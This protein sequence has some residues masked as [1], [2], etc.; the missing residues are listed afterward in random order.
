[1]NRQAHCTEPTLTGENRGQKAKAK[2]ANV[3]ES[4]DEKPGRFNGTIALLS[5]ANVRR[6]R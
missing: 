6:H 5:N 1:M 4:S 3:S 2:E